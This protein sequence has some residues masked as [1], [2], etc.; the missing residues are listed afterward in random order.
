MR[1]RGHIGVLRAGLA[2]L[3]ILIGF[4]DHYPGFGLEFVEKLPA[5]NEHLL[6]DFGSFSV[7]FA[8]LLGIAFARPE[9]SLVRASLIAFLVFALPHLA[10]HVTH[11]EPFDTAE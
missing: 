10:F 3:L 6:N 7:A 5:Y 8:V 1:D 11:L 9:P 2:Y 4:W